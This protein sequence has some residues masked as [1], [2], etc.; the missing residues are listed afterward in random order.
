MRDVNPLTKHLPYI[1]DYLS[2]NPLEGHSKV[3]Q[4]I[5][6]LT[7]SKR[8]FMRQI[9]RKRSLKFSASSQTSQFLVLQSSLARLFSCPIVSKLAHNRRVSFFLKRPRARLPSN[10]LVGPILQAFSEW[11]PLDRAPCFSPHLQ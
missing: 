6:R 11:L 3:E 9:L 1:S 8:N 7:K 5:P 4:G 10:R 2:I